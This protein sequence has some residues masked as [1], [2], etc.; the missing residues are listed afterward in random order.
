MVGEGPDLLARL[1]DTRGDFARLGW[2]EGSNSGGASLATA[3][4][5][6][7]RPHARSPAGPFAAGGLGGGIFFGRAR[8]LSPAMAPALPGC[9]GMS[10]GAFF[11]GD[12]PVAFICGSPAF[13]V[14]SRCSR[15]F[16]EGIPGSGILGAALSGNGGWFMWP[17]GSASAR[18]FSKVAADAGG[19]PAE[20][21][22][23]VVEHPDGH[24]PVSQQGPG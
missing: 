1:R 12:P 2:L 5:A 19:T 7:A 17:P 10:G 16:C 24:G 18:G 22:S 11:G 15:H 6:A 23:T 14:V 13:P 4:S 8:P 9:A 20:C 3:G 21:S